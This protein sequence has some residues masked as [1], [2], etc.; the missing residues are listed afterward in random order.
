[1]HETFDTLLQFDKRA[2][3][4]DRDHLAANARTG[5][6]LLVDIRPRVRQKLLE[7]ERDAFAV[8]IDVQNL[9]VDR[10]ADVHHLGRMPDAAPRHV[11]DVKQTVESTQVDERTE[12]SDVLDLAF[13]HLPD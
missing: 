12:V 4:G 8:P 5:T 2:V 13:P 6:V 7:S 10:G 1:M 9:H 11:G 3:V